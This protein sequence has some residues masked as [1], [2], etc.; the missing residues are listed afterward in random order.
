MNL[1]LGFSVHLRWFPSGGYTS[2]SVSFVA[3]LRSIVLPS[4]TLGLINAAILARMTR[5]CVLDVLSEDYIRTARAKGLKETFVIVKH[6]LRNAL[7]PV[8][9]LIG[10]IYGMLLGGTIVMEEV[11]AI[12]GV[13]RLI[14]GAISQRDF[15]IVQGGLLLTGTLY[16]V[17]NLIVD[18]LYTIM[19]PRIHYT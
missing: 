12:P 13:G 4:V 7:I 17:I 11:F 14:I 15:Q 10:I 8:I 2:L 6:L 18:I 1:I 9:T 19:D 16:A 3:W 5:T